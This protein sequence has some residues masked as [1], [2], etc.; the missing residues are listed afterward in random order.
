MTKPV[1]MTSTRST[2]LLGARACDMVFVIEANRRKNMLMDS[3]IV[4]ATSIKK[5]KGP[6]SRRRLAMTDG[7][8]K[9]S[10]LLK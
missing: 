5:K 1:Y 4:N 10:V 6:G 8:H 7:D 9:V 2:M 3:I